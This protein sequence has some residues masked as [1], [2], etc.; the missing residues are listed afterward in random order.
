MCSCISPSSAGPS[1]LFVS[2]AKITDVKIWR[3]RLRGVCGQ[4]FSSPNRLV[5]IDHADGG[6]SF[7]QKFKQRCRRASSHR[8]R[9]RDPL[10]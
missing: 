10:L 5:G 7:F 4:L 1:R 3:R 2:G 8:A 6:A 9:L